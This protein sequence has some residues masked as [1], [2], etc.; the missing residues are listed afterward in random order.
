MSELVTFLPAKKTTVFTANRDVFTDSTE[1]ANTFAENNPATFD[2]DALIKDDRTNSNIFFD[3]AI[4]PLSELLAGTG[5]QAPDHQVIVDMDSKT[6]IHT[7]KNQYKL[8]KHKDAYNTA[9]QII[10]ELATE[11]LINIEGA[12]IKDSC[13]YKGGRTIREYFFPNELIKINGD[14]IAM[15]LVIINSYDGSTNFSVQVGGFRLVCC[16]GI[17]SGDKIVSLNAQHSSGFQLGQIRGK[18]RTAIKQYKIAGEYW[19]K[20]Y[21]TKLSDAHADRILSQFSMNNGSVSINKFNGFTRLWMQHKKDIGANYWAMLQVLTYWA[22]HHKVSERS[23][24]NAPFLV[25][26]RQNEI[27][28]FMQSKLWNI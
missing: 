19:D 15:R 18:L 2:W 23:Q 7:P 25:Y 24:S 8:T 4:K 22:T 6:V 16:N 11:G 17:V 10:N 21:S 26:Q 3:V 5:I 13:L 27:N 12:V 14:Y 9:N 20:L 28:S 1:L